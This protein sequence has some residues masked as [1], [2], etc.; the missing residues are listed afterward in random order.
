MTNALPHLLANLTA[1]EG[2][3]ANAKAK[4]ATE[5]VAELWRDLFEAPPALKWLEGIEAAA[6]WNTP[7]AEHFAEERGA[8]LF[9]ASADITAKVHDKA[10]AFETAKE[11]RSLPAPFDRTRVLSPATLRD[12]DGALKLIRGEV[13]D[14]PPSSQGWTLKPRIGTAGRGRVAIPSADFDEGELS[15]AFGRL[16]DRGGALLEPWVDRVADYST[17]LLIQPDGSLMLLAT[18]EQVS[19]GAGLVRGHRGLVDSRGRVS[20]GSR[21]DEKLREGAMEMATAASRAGYRG[22]CGVDAFTFRDTEGEIRLRP[23]VEF[24]ARFTVGLLALGQVRRAVPEIRSRLGLS[25]GDLRAWALG[26]APPADGWPTLDSPSVIRPF[27]E[28]GPCLAAALT[29]D[30]LAG[31]FSSP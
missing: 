26:L 8:V 14:P 25:P 5:G 7:E 30:A 15:R 28:R 24:N 31:W 6:W 18:L 11:E 16:A 12:A 9:G 10:F 2:P 17:Q 20:S 1:E 4:A 22:P 23:M 27:R 19:S 21:W 13:S 3:T 29:E